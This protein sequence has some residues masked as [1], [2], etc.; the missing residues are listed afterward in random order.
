MD[1]NLEIQPWERDDIPLGHYDLCSDDDR[2]C[3]YVEQQDRG[4][5]VVHPK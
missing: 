1:P 2:K 5:W 4:M 3:W